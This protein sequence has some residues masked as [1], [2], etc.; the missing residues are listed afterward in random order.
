M[1]YIENTCTDPRFNLALEQYVFDRLAVKEDFFI[2][3]QNANSIIIGK[4]Q[5][6]VEEI[7]AAYVKEH[8]I[9]VVRRLS[10]GGAVFHD[11]GNVNFTFIADHGGGG[12]DFSAFCHPVMDALESLGVKAELS[13]RNDMTIGGQKFSGNSQYIRQG[14]VMH[15]GTILFDSDLET[16]GKALRA[17]E[18]KFLSKGFK[19]VRSRVTNVKPHLPRPISTGEF[20]DCLRSFMFR[21]YHLIPYT[22]TEEDLEAVK[23]LQEEVYDRW[24]WNFGSSPASSIVKK[25]RVE[26]VGQIEIHMEVENGAISKLA[27]Y[28]DYFGNN[29]SGGLARI[30]TGAKL[31]EDAICERLEDTDIQDYFSRLSLEDFCSAMMQ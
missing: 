5:N 2:L 3:W 19:S 12:F 7:N 22:V 27:F 14:R 21:E 9:Q 10:G 18:D 17:P 31:R 20:K 13:G 29:D 6:T 11:L 16:V 8:D 4:H 30:L 1:Y 26:G 25:R 15:H 24:E 28:G 23:K